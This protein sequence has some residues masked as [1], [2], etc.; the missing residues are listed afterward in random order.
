MKLYNVLYVFYVPLILA[1]WLLDTIS[2]MFQVLHDS[3]KTL[4][5]VVE[6]YINESTGKATGTEITDTNKG[7]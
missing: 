6:S 5:L 7:Q 1:E 2:K 3:I 4:T